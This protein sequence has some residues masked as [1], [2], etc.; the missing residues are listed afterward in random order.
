V[1]NVGGVVVGILE[2]V[3]VVPETRSCLGGGS[4][5]ARYSVLGSATMRARFQW[6]DRAVPLVARVI[7]KVIRRV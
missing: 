1:A 6:Q 2:Q 4:G 3:P 7:H 5:C